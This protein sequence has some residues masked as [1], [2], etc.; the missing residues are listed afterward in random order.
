VTINDPYKGVELIRRYSNPARGRHS[1][2]IEIN[3]ALYMNEL[4][5]EKSNNYNALKSDIEK[6]VLF[7]SDYVSAQLIPRAAD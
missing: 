7:L 6:I 4:T 1:L 5:L 2:Q 3:K